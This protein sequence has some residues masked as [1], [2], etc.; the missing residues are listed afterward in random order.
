MPDSK[1]Y[2]TPEGRDPFGLAHQLR[3]GVSVALRTSRRQ[4]KQAAI[5]DISIEELTEKIVRSILASFDV[6]W[7]GS[8][9]TSDDA[10]KPYSPPIY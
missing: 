2:R 7:K 5:V 1:P 6:T 4:L 9:D 3:V 8:T 10:R